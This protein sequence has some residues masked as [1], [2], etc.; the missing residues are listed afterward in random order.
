MV[1]SNPKNTQVVLVHD[2]DSQ[3]H[4]LIKREMLS[5]EYIFEKTIPMES[6]PDGYMDVYVREKE[7]DLNV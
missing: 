4:T 5:D 6:W 2:S 3:H 1:H 7:E